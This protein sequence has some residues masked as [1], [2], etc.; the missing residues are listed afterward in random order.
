MVEC[1][2]CKGELDE[3]VGIYVSEH[4]ISRHKL[5]VKRTVSFYSR[6]SLNYVHPGCVE[7][8]N[9]LDD[10]QFKK[11]TWFTMAQQRDEA[12]AIRRGLKRIENALLALPE[13]TTAVF[14]DELEH[15]RWTYGDGS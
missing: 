9:L 2:A 4:Y 13:E 15:E 6:Y 8:A 11:W 5:E 3:A 7:S 14:R 1:V 10:K 12:A